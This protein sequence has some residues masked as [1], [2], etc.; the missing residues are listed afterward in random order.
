MMSAQEREFS[1]KTLLKGGGALIVGLSIAGAGLAGKAS[2]DPIGLPYPNLGAIDTWLSIGADGTVTLRAG[3]V[4]MGTG[5]TTGLLQIV[6]DELD[7][8]MTKLKFVAGITGVT[9]DQY[10]SS[11]SAAIMSGGPAVRQASAEARAALLQMASTKLGVTVDR[12]SVRDTCVRVARPP[13]RLR[14]RGRG[15]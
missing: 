1:R 5:S 3:K 2:A 14:A 12:L 11:A 6:A 7:V 4:D 10:V 8:S 13:R 15:R 9:P